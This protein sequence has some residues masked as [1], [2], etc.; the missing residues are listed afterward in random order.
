MGCRYH[1]P[2]RWFPRHPVPQARLIRICNN[3]TSQLLC[4]QA[5]LDLDETDGVWAV[6][7]LPGEPSRGLRIARRPRQAPH[8]CG[9]ATA[10]G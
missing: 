8:G 10:Y 3:C 4:A 7:Q 6:I 2:D 9:T 5:A 1:P